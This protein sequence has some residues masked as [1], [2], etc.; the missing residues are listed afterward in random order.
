[1]RGR[2][3]AVAV[4]V[5]VVV[6]SGC[7][8][9]TVLQTERRDT[10]SSIAAEEKGPCTAASMP[11]SSTQAGA[12][13][14]YPA[15]PAVAVTRE[16]ALA[17]GPEPIASNRAKLTSVGELDVVADPTGALNRAPRLLPGHA[18]TT[19]VWVVA[20]PPVT[21]MSGRPTPT[22]IIDAT[23]GA[24]LA[25]HINL[26]GDVF[27]ALTD[28]SQATGCRPPYGVL[29]RSEVQGTHIVPT[30]ATVRILLTTIDVLARTPEGQELAQC[31]VH[32]CDAGTPVWVVI[33]QA[34]DH[35][36]QAGDSRPAGTPS[37][38]QPPGSWRVLALD[39]RTGP[40]TTGLAGNRGDGAGQP[41]AAFTSLTDLAPGA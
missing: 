39:A 6:A 21:G 35:S 31:A 11:V 8:S 26:I 19:P 22:S 2:R 28:R 14:S 5:A 36:L 20:G 23:N 4:T 38:S 25:E 34:P 24:V 7:K 30:G 27:P 9:R 15:A 12:A 29:T 33:Q 13:L 16:Q 17:R 40:Q 3:V 18:V 32:A 41:P 10:A 1:M 37:P